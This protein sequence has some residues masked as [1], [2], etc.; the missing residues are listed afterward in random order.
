MNATG[1]SSALVYSRPKKYLQCRMPLRTRDNCRNSC[2]ALIFQLLQMLPE[3]E[4][5]LLINR[6]APSGHVEKRLLENRDPLYTNVGQQ[7]QTVAL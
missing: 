3:T 7:W 6:H 1:P 4:G 5:P 2:P